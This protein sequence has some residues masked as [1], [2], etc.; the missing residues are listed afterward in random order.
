MQYF[1]CESSL[2]ADVF[3]NLFDNL[4]MPIAQPWRFQRMSRGT[5]LTVLLNTNGEGHANVTWQAFD[6][7]TREQ[8]SNSENLDVPPMDKIFITS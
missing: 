2:E 7:G 1:S 3:V 6:A 5:S 8:I 4:A